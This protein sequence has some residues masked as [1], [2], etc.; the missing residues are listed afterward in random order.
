MKNLDIHP[1]D[2][3]DLNEP[4]H[5]SFELL[6]DYANGMVSKDTR[7]NITKHLTNC[8]ICA[9]IVEGINTYKTISATDDANN[10][11]S[12]T[13]YADK[14][15]KKQLSIIK[16]QQDLAQS[17]K[18]EL[19]KVKSLNSPPNNSRGFRRLLSIAA[20]LLLVTGFVL[21]YFHFSQ[22]NVQELAAVEMSEIETV[23]EEIEEIRSRGGSR[24]GALIGNGSNS[25]TATAKLTSTDYLEEGLKQLQVK[26]ALSPKAITNLEIVLDIGTFS[27]KDIARWYLSLAHLQLDQKNAAKKYL[28]EI[29][30][31]GSSYKDKATKLLKAID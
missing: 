18:E 4:I 16:E 29:V 2:A 7:Q 24:G 25:E 1:S 15:E 22:P 31:S 11:L 21:S 10:K 5:H 3:N 14:F 30:S 17:K 23:L 27:E 6:N 20:M 8:D 12:V 28:Q 13:E 9:T 19:G 26:P